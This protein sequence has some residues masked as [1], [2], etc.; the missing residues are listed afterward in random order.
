MATPPYPPRLKV[1]R[2][3]RP[4]GLK[5]APVSRR[6][7]A[8]ALQ[9]RPPAGEPEVHAAPPEN[10]RTDA[11]DRWLNTGRRLNTGRSING[12]KAAGTAKLDICRFSRKLP[13]CLRL[14]GVRELSATLTAA[15]LHP[16]HTIGCGGGFSTLWSP[17]LPQLPRRAPQLP[18]LP[19]NL[20]L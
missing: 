13:R 8:K 6:P 14:S 9:E 20:Q 7:P 2:S 17:Q 15:T 10:H 19:R 11:G 1:S 16:I 5:P 4:G 12:Q 18:Q 3:M